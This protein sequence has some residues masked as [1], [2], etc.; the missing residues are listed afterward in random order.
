MAASPIVAPPPRPKRA[1]DKHL[2]KYA[3][4]EPSH[5]QRLEWL[6]AIILKHQLYVP[7]LTQLNEPADGR[8]RFA[9]LTEAQ[10]FADL[11]NEINLRL[12][13]SCSLDEDSLKILKKLN[14]VR[15]PGVQN[16]ENKL[17]GFMC[18]GLTDP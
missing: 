1:T 12:A 13:L 3:S 9:R 5:T 17:H 6:K 14:N 4:L 8:P 2:Y 18:A 7:N 11:W 16:A 15:D 10:L